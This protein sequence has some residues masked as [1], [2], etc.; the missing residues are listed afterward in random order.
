MFEANIG[1]GITLAEVELKDLPFFGNFV[2][3]LQP[4]VNVLLGRNGYGKSHLLRGIVAMLLNDSKVTGQFFPD[5]PAR[6]TSSLFRVDIR[7]GAGTESAVRTPGLRKHWCPAARNSGYDI[8]KSDDR[9]LRF[10]GVGFAQTGCRSFVQ[11]KLF[12][13]V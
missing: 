7:K 8:E 10:L 2:W 4:G 6:G 1:Q 12:A 13:R 5:R 11:E 3:K 9:S